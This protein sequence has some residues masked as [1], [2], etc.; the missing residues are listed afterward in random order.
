MSG[1][2]TPTVNK[3]PSRKHRR[4]PRNLLAEYVRRQDHCT[5]LETHIWH[6]KRFHMSEQWGYMVPVSPND[7]S[8]RSS[9]RANNHFCIMQVAQ[10]INYLFIDYILQGFNR[11]VIR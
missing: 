5:W 7:K 8:A 3:R 1:T 4:K 2:G 11:A 9:Y 10:Y 6:A